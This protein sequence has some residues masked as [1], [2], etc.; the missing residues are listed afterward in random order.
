MTRLEPRRQGRGLFFAQCNRSGGRWR[1]RAAAALIGIQ[2]RRER[3]RFGGCGPVL[4]ECFPGLSTGKQGCEAARLSARSPCRPPENK[5]ALPKCLTR[6]FSVSPLQEIRM[7]WAQVASMKNCINIAQFGRENSFATH[8]RVDRPTYAHREVFS[9]SFPT[10]RRSILLINSALRASASFMSLVVCF[11]VLVFDP[12]TTVPPMTAA[13]A[14]IRA[15][16]LNRIAPIIIAKIK[17]PP[18]AAA[19]FE[20]TMIFRHLSTTTACSSM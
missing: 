18:E 11:M 17:I 15:V 16:A 13:I 6:N 8:S 10:T 4:P 14:P 12:R 3:K 5:T 20:T 19:N 9:Y 2:Q 1:Q 7:T